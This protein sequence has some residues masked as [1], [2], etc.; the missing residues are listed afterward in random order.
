MRKQHSL[1]RGVAA[2]I[3]VVAVLVVMDS[4]GPPKPVTA[5]TAPCEQGTAVSNPSGNP[6]LVSD[7]EALLAARDTLRGTETLNW[8]SDT[9]IA[10]WEGITV[11]GTPE[12]VTEL[13]I[14][15]WTSQWR[16]GRS[17]TLDGTV[18]AQL[19]EL[20]ELQ[21]LQLSRNE[22]TGTIPAELADLAALTSLQ[23][24]GNELSGGIPPEL[25]ELSNLTTLNLRDNPLGG[26]IPVELGKLANLGALYLESTQ[27]TGSIPASLGDVNLWLLRLSGNAGLSGCVP[28]SLQG[29]NND[30]ASLE[31]SFCTT[32]TTHTLTTS[33]TGN[34]RISPLPGSYSYLSGTSVTVTATADG[35]YRVA[36]WGG[37][38][39][40]TATTCDLTMDANRTASVTFERI[41]HTLTVTAG[42]DGSIDPGPGIHRY[43]PGASVTLTAMADEGYAIGSWGGACSGSATTCTLTMDAD[44]T[45][46]VTFEGIPPPNPTTL[47]GV[48][49]SVDTTLLG[50]GDSATLTI[51]LDSDPGEAIEVQVRSKGTGSND[52]TI[53][54][55]T[56]SWTAANWQESR[57]VTVRATSDTTDEE[58]ETHNV[59]AWAYR[60]ALTT[61]PV[62]LPTRTRLN[63]FDELFTLTPSVTGP[64]SLDLAT[65]T[66]YGKGETVELTATPNEGKYFRGWGGGCASVAPAVLTC[67]IALTTDQT[68]SATFGDEPVV[69]VLLVYSKGEHDTLYLE[70]VGGPTNATK[71]QYRQ[72]GWDGATPLTWGSWTDIPGSST[73]TRNHRVTGLMEEQPYDYQV[74][75]VN[76]TN[77]GTASVVAAGYGEGTTPLRIGI[78]TLDP[79]QVAE[80]DGETEWRIHRLGF[81]IVI[82]DGMRMR[83]GGGFTSAG[84]PNGVWLYDLSTGSSLLLT[85]HGKE[86]GRDIV[87]SDT[88]GEG[89][90]GASGESEDSATPP[91]T[92]SLFDRIVESVTVK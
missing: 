40:G 50:E 69:P 16:I 75:P 33:V 1:F 55:A 25:G 2:L 28:A 66:K 44:K 57:S 59:D 36:S 27:L 11:S 4:S 62:L 15:G 34:G 87:S 54:P 18:P 29:I 45:A 37:N 20:S 56:V 84:G 82:P 30:L 86:N 61:T 92:G 8:S 80:G 47:T 35:G 32:T 23:L 91:S 39:S 70:W 78:P 43:I 6:G 90:G 60:S 53:S 31:L 89:V 76:G 13:K 19:G 79:F 52:L 72:R 3:A 58:G 49:V 9:A 48:S 88:S 51:T 17:I 46:S 5:T 77:P 26:G 64:G 67:D 63:V 74:R 14:D 38:C 68:V 12:R 41:T 83:A 73:S 10:D 22:L 7:C 21:R 42:E 85:A 71:W 65:A 81:V 24:Y